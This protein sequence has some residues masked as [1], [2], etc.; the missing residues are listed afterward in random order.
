M[1]AGQS[2]CSRL[3]FYS[4]APQRWS[5]CGAAR[6]V[7]PPRSARAVGDRNRRGWT[8]GQQTCWPCPAGR[9]RRGEVNTR[10]CAGQDRHITKKRAKAGQRF[11]R[12]GCVSAAE[13]GGT[14]RSCQHG[15]YTP[16][17]RSCGAG[18][19]PVRL[20]ERHEGELRAAG[21]REFT[22]QTRTDEA[23]TWRRRSAQGSSSSVASGSGVRRH[24]SPRARPDIVEGRSSAGNPA[25][26]GRASTRHG[27]GRSVSSTEDI[28][29]GGSL[30]GSPRCGGWA[31]GRHDHW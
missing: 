12:R 24:S 11:S 31:S 3:A 15:D 5:S 13:T 9:S 20:R 21:V 14:R 2:H 4:K 17:G 23:S 1:L 27:Q 26:G 30:S 16:A 7:I 18:Q 19:G 22:A 6:R 29:E 28:V 10:C 25:G 8:P